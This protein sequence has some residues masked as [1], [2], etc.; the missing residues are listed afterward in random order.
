VHFNTRDQKI[1][2]LHL[3]SLLLSRRQL[4]RHTQLLTHYQVETPL[5][6][7]NVPMTGDDQPHL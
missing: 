5:N 6:S 2:V 1:Q 3:V 7:A 4:R